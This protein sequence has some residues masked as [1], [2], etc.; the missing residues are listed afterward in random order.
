MLA[1][2][3]SSPGL[4]GGEGVEML[5]IESAVAII[6]FLEDLNESLDYSPAG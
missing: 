2:K 1:S 3:T 6:T 5:E 4:R